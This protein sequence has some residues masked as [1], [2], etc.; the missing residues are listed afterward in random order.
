MP[1]GQHGFWTELLLFVKVYLSNWQSYATGGVITGLISVGERLSG[2]SLSKKRYFLIFIVSFSLA[3]FFLAWRDE[4]RRAEGLNFINTQLGTENKILKQDK[5]TLETKLASKERPI[6]V[7]ATP[8]PEIQR[9]LKRQDEELEKLKSEMPSPRKKALLLSN[10]MLKFLGDRIKTQPSSPGMELRRVS[11]EQWNQTMN[12]YTRKYET[13]MRETGA[14]Y[15]V[16]FGTRISSVLDDMQS[17]G[18]DTA[19]I[20]ICPYSNGN[21]FGIEDCGTRIGVLAEKFPH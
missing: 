2:K 5:E 17:N 21:T 4:F 16:L 8:D 10:D 9:L 14:D 18:L 7:Q 12:E 15:Q 13:W 3:A 11:A 6:I 19:S 1:G 20:R